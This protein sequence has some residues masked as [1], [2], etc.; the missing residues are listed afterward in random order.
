MSKAMR[1]ADAAGRDRRT[2][3]VREAAEEALDLASRDDGLLATAAPQAR[4]TDLQHW[5]DLCA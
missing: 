2:R 4:V 5:I 1:R 3:E